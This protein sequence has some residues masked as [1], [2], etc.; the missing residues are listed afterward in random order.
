M[1]APDGCPPV[2]YDL[3][4]QCWTLDS[5]VRPSFR[6]LREKLQHIRAK[7]LYLWRGGPWEAKGGEEGGGTQPNTAVKWEEEEEEEKRKRDHLPPACPACWPVGLPYCVPSPD[8]RRP[9]AAFCFRTGTVFLFVLYSFCQTVSSS[10]LFPLYLP[11]LTCSLCLFSLG[12]SFFSS[13]TRKIP[14]LSYRPPPP[15]PLLNMALTG[16]EAGLFLHVCQVLFLLLLWLSIIPGSLYHR[17]ALHEF[18][19]TL[20]SFHPSFYS[21]LPSAWCQ[22]WG[23]RSVPKCLQTTELQTSLQHFFK[24]DCCGLIF[25]LLFLRNLFYCFLF[26]REVY[27]TVFLFFFCAVSPTSI[28]TSDCVKRPWREREQEER[29]FGGQYRMFVSRVGDRTGQDRTITGGQE[30]EAVHQHGWFII[31]GLVFISKHI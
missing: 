13:S 28:T 29:G 10:L 30:G 21:L 26:F 12:P 8:L 1:D 15:P 6:M 24:L 23:L 9:P 25:L 20:L 4:K 3:M 22:V 31:R 2:V 17:V 27:Q 14:F 19:P 18:S 5:V 16:G 11:L 7:E